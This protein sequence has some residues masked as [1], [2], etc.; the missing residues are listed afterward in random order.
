MWPDT[1]AAR[2]ILTCSVLAQHTRHVCTVQ[3]LDKLRYELC[4]KNF[5]SS[6]RHASLCDF[7]YTEHQHT[8][9]HIH[10]LFLT[11]PLLRLVKIHGR[12]ALRRNTH[13]PKN[14]ESRKTCYLQ[15]EQI[16]VVAGDLVWSLIIQVRCNC[17]DWVTSFR[18]RSTLSCWISVGSASRSF[19][20]NSIAHRKYF[21][22]FS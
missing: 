22:G 1:F 7:Q 17:C 10:L 2:H 8:L 9:S 13:F 19:G 18:K 14:E 3:G 21:A 4:C 11:H 20:R 15:S 12:M 6:T 16:V 5:H